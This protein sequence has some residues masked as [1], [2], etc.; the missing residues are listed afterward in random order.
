MTHS[1]KSIQP[2]TSPK[3]RATNLKKDALQMVYKTLA[4]SFHPDINPDADSTM[5]EINARYNEL[6]ANKLQAPKLS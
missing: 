2:T 4:K 6:R 1:E 3:P 5:Q